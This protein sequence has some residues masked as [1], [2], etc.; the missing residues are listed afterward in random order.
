MFCFSNIGSIFIQSF[1]LCGYANPHS[2]RNLD[3][4]DIQ[5]IENFIQNDLKEIIVRKCERLECDLKTD[6][7]EHLFGMFVD[8]EEKFKLMR[9]DKLLLLEIADYLTQKCNKDGMESFLRHFELPRRYKIS[10]TDTATFDFGFFYSKKRKQRA[11]TIINQ[12]DLHA[13]CFEKLNKFFQSYI[14]L[15]PIRPISGDIVKII[16]TGS[17][18][19]ADVICVF[20]IENENTVDSLLK[21]YSVTFDRGWNFSNLRK[22]M[23]RHCKSKSTTTLTL[24]ID[25]V[26]DDM[27][28]TESMN[29]AAIRGK[30]ILLSDIGMNVMESEADSSTIFDQK[31]H[32]FVEP[33]YSEAHSRNNSSEEQTMT[34][35][36]PVIESSQNSND[37]S[38]NSI[39][40]DQFTTQSLALLRAGLKNKEQKKSMDLKIDDKTFKISISQI[41]PDGNCMFATIAHQLNLVKCNSK[42]HDDLTADLR[43]EV[44]EYIRD[45]IDNFKHTIQLR[46]RCDEDDIN[47]AC[48]QFLNELE[49]EGTW[50]GMETVY[51]VSSLYRVNIVVF[52]E[53]GPFYLG[54]G[55]N[56]EYS[57]TIFMAYRIGGV[58]GKIKDGKKISKNHYNHY[59][60]IYSLDENL[61]FKCAFDFSEKMTR[62]NSMLSA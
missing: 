8:A 40:Y 26:N 22:H 53:D 46:L 31:V 19:R 61:L 30:A 4:D 9:G 60:T 35:T 6:D 41:K 24:K 57:R 62:R 16:D 21:K 29:L 45:N 33:E 52:N 5:F 14:N 1:R 39:I 55:F 15:E 18:F 44:V 49:C 10:K 7:L 17:G 42:Q 50:G 48:L 12:D 59:D 43:K 38:L 34:M 37:Q 47:Q 27:N 54:N 23:Q 13:T 3:D 20:C 28:D 25:P 58:R 36:V 11:K 2:F 32:T 51:A 56:H